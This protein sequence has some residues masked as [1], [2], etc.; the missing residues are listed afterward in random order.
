MEDIALQPAH[1]LAAAIR[2]GDVSSRELLEYY[3][4][5]VEA[6]NPLVNAVVTT[7]PDGA[8]G[9]ADAADAELARC[10]DIGPLHGV[11]MT[12]KDTF[13]TAGMRTT[14]GLPAWDHVPEGDAEA[15]RR[16]RCAGAVIFGKTNTP[17]QA[18]D[19]QTY[20]AIFGTT[21]NPWDTARTTGGSSGGA[22]AAVATGM[23]ALELGSDIGGSIRFP[24]NWTGVCGHKTTW[25]I[26]SQA[27][28]LPP[29]PG[30]LASTDLA[31]V[32]PLARDVTDLELALDVIA[33]AAGDAAVGWRLELPPPR[34][35]ALEDLRLALWLGD[36]DYPVDAEVATVLA[37]AADA[38]QAGGARLVD[39]RPAVAM[40]DVVRLYQ[41]FLYPI[42]LSGMGQQSFD[43]MVK[44]AAS[45]ADDDD[46][47][48]ARTA[49]FATQRYRDWAFATEK[50][51]QLRAL[52][53][54]YFVD[55]DALLTPVAMVPAIAHDH[56]EPF[57]DRVIE[58]NGAV[59]PYTDLM[60]WV[61]LA[62]LAHLPATV[63]PVGRTASGLPVGMQIIG[64]YLEDRTTLTAGR[65]VE[66]VLGGF[67]APPGV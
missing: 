49:R 11:P 57:T 40:P 53:A 65:L 3:L 43:G 54:N 7:D 60:A 1:V 29:A 50:R 14:C 15:V 20:N 30:R 12:V 24:A 51:E 18:G 35:T 46:R 22:A 6:V 47:P 9:A 21:N 8:R 39:K 52:M 32:G 13:Q 59:R 23:T 17:A 48:L 63:V 27:G 38:L 16:L 61:A 26:V 58:V 56:R 41:Q 66:Q 55:V 45:L 31:V 2:R 25:G 67:V 10:D 4:A 62:T 28:H 37:A 19:W 5:R 36:S 34:A 42:L 64:P 33:G 44:L